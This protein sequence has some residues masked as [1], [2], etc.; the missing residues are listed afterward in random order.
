MTLDI[1]GGWAAT[2]PNAELFAPYREMNATGGWDP[3]LGY[4][5]LS[6]RAQGCQRQG[7][8]SW[9]TELGRAAFPPDKE[10]I[11]QLG[12]PFQSQVFLGVDYDAETF[13][14]RPSVATGGRLRPPHCAVIHVVT[15]VEDSAE[16]GWRG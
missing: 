2:R 16:S 7:A 11:V 6:S 3:V 4:L 9:S 1:D 10:P 15:T 12:A 5:P 14:S 8:G 13:S